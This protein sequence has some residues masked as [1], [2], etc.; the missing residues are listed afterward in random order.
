MFEYEAK[1]GRLFIP[2]TDKNDYY[3]LNDRYQVWQFDGN[4]FVD[5]GSQPHKDFHSSLSEYVSLLQYFETKDYI[6]RVD[7]LADK[8]L[9]F[10]T[11]KKPK[12]MTD[13]PDKVI[14]KG[15]RNE[16]KPIN[17]RVKCGD[18]YRFT[19][20]DYEYLVSYSETKFDE[21]GLGENHDYLVIKKSGKVVMKQEKLRNKG[22]RQ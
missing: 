19:R 21:N 18:G 22:K 4:R 17:E 6:I 7:S 5:K 12:T 20:N 16:Y 11:W 13:Q 15:C 3:R 9:R 2:L 1:T 8:S 10:A 14:D